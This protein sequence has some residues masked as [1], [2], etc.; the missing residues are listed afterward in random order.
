MFGFGKREP[1]EEHEARGETERV[2]HEIRQTLRVSGVNLNFRVWATFAEFFPVMW[3]ALRPNVETRAFEDAADRVRA[4]AVGA[5]GPLGRVRLPESAALGESQA[6]QVRAALAL[7]HYVNPK[8]LVLTSAVRL[9][10]A[11]ETV[12]VDGGGGAER[13]VRGTPAKMYPME[14]L[15]EE[16]EDERVRSI[17]AD[18]RETLGLSRVN[19]DYRTLA[20]WPD[21]LAAAWDGL[22]PIAQGDAHRRAADALREVARREA[23]DL[24]H[25]LPLSRERVEALGEEVDEVVKT[26]EQFEQLLP[27]LIL[28]VALLSLDWSSADA[29]ARSPFPAE[30]APP[31]PRAGGAR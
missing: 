20:L 1:V 13:I 28:N 23:R 5:S 18:I 11:G 12:G 24:P 25:P 29:L 21:Y 8:L 7:Y 17:F 19:S 9:A 15:P 14:M 2:Y 10:L 22:K 6:Y 3:D 26:T 27:G 31:S 4:A 30:T 16:P